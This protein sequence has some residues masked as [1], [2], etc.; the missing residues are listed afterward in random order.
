M[1]ISVN[2]FMILLLSISAF[3][4]VYLKYQ[5]R[6][7]NIQLEKQEKSYT[8]KLNQHKRLL[9]TKANYEKKL[10]QKSYKELLNMDIPKKNQII[11]LNLTTSN[12]GI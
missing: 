11:Y 7:I 2:L 3:S 6:F 10:S 5:N 12:G 9:D 8:M 1:K 4:V